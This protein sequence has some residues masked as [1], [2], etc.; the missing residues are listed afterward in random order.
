MFKKTIWYINREYSCGN[1]ETVDEF[2]EGRKYALEMLKNYR[3]SDAS[4]D[5][6]MSRRCCK[7]WNTD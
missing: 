1:F 2:D 4:A 3:L 6:R 7:D 5:Y